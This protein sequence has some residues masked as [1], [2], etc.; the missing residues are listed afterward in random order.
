M[1]DFTPEVKNGWLDGFTSVT[2]Y[3]ALFVG[4]PAGA[5]VEISGANYARLPVVAGD[6]SVASNGFKHNA[7]AVTFPKA[8]GIQSSDDITHWA[9][10]DAL[11]AGNLKNSDDLP[12]AQQQ[13]IVEN[14]TVEFGIG[15][16]D[17]SISNAA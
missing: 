11:A 5:G 12:V 14:N 9:L 4:D 7:N 13:P 10:F 6:W 16:I 17:L 3:L 2:L 15:D 1:G 8:T